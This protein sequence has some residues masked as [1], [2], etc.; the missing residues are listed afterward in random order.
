MLAEVVGLAKSAEFK[1]AVLLVHRVTCKAGDVGGLRGG[2]EHAVLDVVAY[3]VVQLAGGVRQELSHNRDGLVGIDDHAGAVEVGSTVA[4]RVQVA[5][6]RVTV[7]SVAVR[8]IGTAAVRT[9]AH[10]L[11]RSVARV[12]GIGVGDL[13]LELASLG[14]LLEGGLYC[15]LLASKMS[16]SLQQLPRPPTPEFLSLVEGTQPST[17][18]WTT[19]QKGERCS[20]ERHQLTWPLIHFRSMAHWVSQ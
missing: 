13:K 16:I 18:A 1:R 3:D 19:R 12:E 11:G 14:W 9:A 7:A 5:A 4:V 6:I 17:L 10:V 8:R 20:R 2:D 15:T